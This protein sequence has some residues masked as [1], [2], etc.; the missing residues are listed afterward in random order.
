MRHITIRILSGLLLIAVIAGIAVL[1]FNAGVARGTGTNIQVPSGQNGNPTYPFYGFPFWWPFPFFGFGFLGLLAL[2]FLLSVAF[3]A[4]RMMLFGPRIGWRRWQ[5]G[6]G[7]W[8]EQGAGEDIPPMFTE[9]HRRMH[10]AEESKP[11]DQATQ[12]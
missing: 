12:K 2:L 10:A 5:R 9:M 1:A 4:F 6:Y 8:G 7:H 3:G 11:A